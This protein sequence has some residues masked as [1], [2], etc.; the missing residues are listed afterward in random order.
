MRNIVDNEKANN[1][2]KSSAIQGELKWARDRI[3]ELENEIED[4]N[5]TII[6]KNGEYN[7]FKE[8]QE[9]EYQTFNNKV[10]Q[11]ESNVGQLRIQ[12]QEKDSA[13][14]TLSQKLNIRDSEIKD[15]K[16]RWSS[17]KMRESDL[18]KD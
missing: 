5:N 17:T 16:N 12:L 18:I 6:N 10:S 3:K 14:Q 15:S 11:L 9:D 2:Q 7:Y 13:L 4:K 8:K 1:G